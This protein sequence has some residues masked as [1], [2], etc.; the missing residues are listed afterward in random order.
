MASA[1]AARAAL[2]GSGPPAGASSSMTFLWAKICSH[3]PSR[4][5]TCLRY[6]SQTP[7]RPRTS[8]LRE[9][10]TSRRRLI[11]LASCATLR[12]PGSQVCAAGRTSRLCLNFAFQRKQNVSRKDPSRP[13]AQERV[14]V[15]AKIEQLSIGLRA[16]QKTGDPRGPP[17]FAHQCR[18]ARSAAARPAWPSASF[19]TAA[20][21]RS[22]RA[23]GQRCSSWGPRPGRRSSRRRRR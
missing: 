7:P 22:G 18:V 21:C 12:S 1:P 3:Q 16:P 10:R 4:C 5:I 11:L 6:R 20:P 8:R 9:E 17:A 23:R 13:R 15:E 19:R 2:K 14:P